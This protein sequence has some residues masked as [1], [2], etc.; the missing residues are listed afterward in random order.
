MHRLSEGFEQLNF[1]LT[2]YDGGPED[3]P[4]AVHRA[5]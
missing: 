2:E 5:S 1:H 3:L 4:Y